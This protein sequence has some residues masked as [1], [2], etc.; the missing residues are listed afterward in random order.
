VWTRMLHHPI[1]SIRFDSFRSDPIRFDSI[2]FDSI[3][4]DLSI[5]HVAI[6]SGGSLSS[7]RRAMRGFVQW[8]MG[9]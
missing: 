1:D 7:D 4:Q 3:D 6:I 8:W 2:R 5:F 9:N